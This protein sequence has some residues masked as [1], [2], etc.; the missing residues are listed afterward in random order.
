MKKTFRSILAG[1]IALL[2][3]SCY[4]DSDLQKKYGDLNDRVTAIENV[5]NAEVGGIDDLA[6]RLLAAEGKLTTHEGA[7]TAAQTSILSRLDASD[8]ATDGKIKNLEDAITALQGAD[9][10]IKKDLAE[11]I[12]KIAIVS[13]EE[14]DGNWKFTPAVGDPFLLSK[15][16]ANV[17]NSGLVTILPVDGVDYW[18]VVGADGA[19]VSTD[20]PV[21]HPDYQIAFQVTADGKLTYTVNGGEPVETGVSTADLSGQKYLINEVEVAENG[22]YVTITIGEAEYVLP[23]YEPAP[24]VKVKAGKTFFDYA[25]TKELEVKIDGVSNLVVMNQPYGWKAKVK[26]SV[27]TVTAPSEANVDADKDGAVVLHGSADGSCMTAVLNVSVGEGLSMTLTES[28]EIH[29]VNPLVVEQTSMS[30]MGASIGFADAMVGIMTVEEFESYSSVEDMLIAASQDYNGEYFS[31]TYLQSIKD[32]LGVGSYYNEGEYEVDEFSFKIED[33]ASKVLWPRYNMEKGQKY[34]VY[35]VPMTPNYVFEDYL[36]VYYEPISIE[37]TENVTS[38]EIE[39]ELALYGV[40]KVMVGAVAAS[41]FKNAEVPMTFEEFMND[42]TGGRWNAFQSY[43]EWI[44]LGD[45]CVSGD[46]VEVTELAWE[47]D[48]VPGET[49]YIWIMP[50]KEGKSIAEYS[51]EKDFMPYVY[52]IKTTPLEKGAPE[53]EVSLNEDKTNYSTIAVDVVPAEGSKV[54]STF[55]KAG[56]VDEMTEDEIVAATMASCYFPSEEEETVTERDL[57]DGT[58]MTFVAVT[59]KDGKYSLVQLPV[60][61]LAY[62]RTDEIVASME[63]CVANGDGTYT[64]V[65]KVEGDATMVALSVEYSAFEN[66]YLPEEI[67]LNGASGVLE[68]FYSA[69]V[70]EGVATVNFQLGWMGGKYVQFI[71]YKVDGDSVLMS[72]YAQGDIPAS[73]DEDDLGGGFFPMLP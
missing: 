53:S 48:L 20:V 70:V 27:L 18:A 9:N 30:M 32:Y 39:L 7:F 36:Y 40:E 46:V 31:S 51:F 52:T 12:A 13:V 16:L 22:K 5:L 33:M 35:A 50:L 34:V 66:I 63:S 2:A 58:T 11:A 41:T 4:D 21:G 62:P 49:Y 42:K 57:S 17:D 56:V 71:A 15:P 28:G 64:A 61:T 19:P 1:A 8:G 29:I 67:F 37:Y 10:S 59:V 25:E 44:A 65:I 68:G 54:Y 24:M 45:E 55:F 6:A 60:Q 43:N 72:E 38:T 47:E 26:G 14:V 23:M 69:P 3:V 73:E